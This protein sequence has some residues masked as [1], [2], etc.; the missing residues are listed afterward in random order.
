LTANALKPIKG[1]FL[2]SGG[3]GRVLEPVEGQTA[4]FMSPTMSSSKTCGKSE[5][6][7]S[8]SNNS[9]ANFMNS[10]QEHKIRD[11]TQTKI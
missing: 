9:G 10:K 4:Q 1:R 6:N 11:V 5:N 3:A 7:E 2:T 8:Y